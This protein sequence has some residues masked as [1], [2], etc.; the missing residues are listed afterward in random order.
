MNLTND[1]GGGQKRP[2]SPY[3]RPWAIQLAITREDHQ[4]VHLLN[5]DGSMTTVPDRPAPAALA[6]LSP[7]VLAAFERDYMASRHRR[8]KCSREDFASGYATC[9]EAHWLKGRKRR[10]PAP[11]DELEHSATGICLACE[12]STCQKR[13]G[14]R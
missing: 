2:A 5:S 12:A 13:G 7:N 11:P 14:Q 10:P 9:L 1:A 4:R 8:P 3:A 6:G